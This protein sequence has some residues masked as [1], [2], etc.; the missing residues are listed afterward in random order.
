MKIKTK[1]EVYPH[2]LMPC[3]P[4]RGCGR[5]E[6]HC[7]AIGGPN[8]LRQGVGI[9]WQCKKCGDEIYLRLIG[10]KADREEIKKV[11]EK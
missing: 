3:A 7:L 1:K 9:Y 4:A 6:H 2:T 8:A 5:E 10:N 11:G